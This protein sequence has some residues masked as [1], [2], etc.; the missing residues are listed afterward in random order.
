MFWSDSC[1]AL[2]QNPA[3]ESNNQSDCYTESY[4]NRIL[5]NSSENEEEYE[6]AQCENEC[7]LVFAQPV[8][9]VYP[10]VDK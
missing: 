3:E 1:L 9:S 6:D 2:D 4:W 10:F 5:N 7:L 8:V